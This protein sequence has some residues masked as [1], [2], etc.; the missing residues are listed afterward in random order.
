MTGLNATTATTISKETT[1]M[2]GSTPPAAGAAIHLAAI[3]R[4][5]CL[6]TAFAV[7]LALASAASAAPAHAAFGIASFDGEVAADDAHAPFTQAGG[8]PYSASTSFELNTAINE[9]GFNGPDGGGLK[10]ARVDL[11]PG[12]IGNPR[13][14]PRCPKT[15]LIPSF[16]ETFAGLDP[17]TVCP[18]E[19]IVGIA[20]LKFTAGGGFIE[21]NAT[22]IFNLEPP[23][24]VTAQFGFSYINQKAFLDAV[25]REDG[26][27]GVS[28]RSRFINQGAPLY[29]VS[30]T[31][32]GVPADSS[33]D[34]QR[35]I[36]FPLPLEFAP[37]PTCNDFGGAFPL[38]GPSSSDIEPKALL[39]NPT[40]CTPPGEGLETTLHVESWAAG[41]ATDTASFESHLPPGAD[42]LNPLPPEDWGAPQGPT[43]CEDV[44]FDP[45]V[46]VE[47]TETRPDAPTGLDLELTMPTDGL[48]NPDGIAQANLKR[49]RITLPEGMTINPAAA[50]G[51]VACDDAQLGIGT[52]RPVACPPAAKIGTVSVE[53]PLLDEPLAGAVYV[54]SQASG[55]PASG[56]MFRIAIAIDDADTGVRIK[57]P[58][59]VSADPR[60]GRLV[61]T[62]D[63]NPQVPFSK[64]TVSL[65]SGARAPLANPSTCGPKTITSELSP[66]SAA[67]PDAPSA[68]EVVVD[69]DTFVVECP[70]ANGFAPSFRAGSVNATGGAFSPFAA[71]IERRQGEQFLSGVRVDMPKGLLARL[72]GVELCSA[73]VAAE[74]TA[75]SC[76]AG[77]RVGTATIGAGSG[78]PFHL[79]GPVYLTGPYKGAPYGLSVQVHA[80]AGPFDLGIVKVAN[81][82]HVDPVTAQ[83][84]VVSDRLPQ[85]V[86]G[87]PVRLRSVN[88]DVDR[89]GF[90][91]NPTSCEETRVGATLTS[92]TGAVRTTGSRFQVGD[93][94]SLPF[95]PRL[96]LRLIGRKQT[97]TGKH[98]G[99][100][101][102]VRQT[103]LGEAGI[104]KAV[105]RL[106]RTLA[107]DADNARALCEFADGIRDDLEKRCPEGS[108]VGRARATTPLLDRPLTGNVYFVKNVR[109]DPRTGRQIRTLPMIVAAL[110]GE[111]AINLKGTSSVRGGRLVSTFAGVPDAPISRFDLDIAGGRRGI[112][113][114]TDS[115]DGPLSVCRGPQTAQV[116]TDGQN[117]KQRDFLVRVKT[118]CAKP[119][120][121]GRR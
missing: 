98:P 7:L 34:S 88:V 109:V 54:R 39:T 23:P 1:S 103:G 43:G 63:D 29:G 81:A 95:K 14:V 22:P 31:L 13:A 18:R 59:S 68:A 36:A 19:T 53:T 41:G 74:G 2:S 107:L 108:I 119:K 4:K 9:Q 73:A 58:G 50:A 65:K 40:T 104:G 93:C 92:V 67:D 60:S 121:S 11:P 49:A 100:R 78:S 55:D 33:H 6:V 24:G 116:M 117:G 75:G 86:K 32:W 83:V 71:R 30:V 35:C 8:H 69:T 20:A 62:F 70:A 114:V 57:L 21:T 112:L 12:L 96:A 56:E 46:S 82:L 25:L 101:A 27:Y 16:S 38:L 52:G 15:L 37:V 66:W 51:L 42:I 120:G 105:V 113:L 111:I 76:P 5:A 99:V 61:T 110:R 10:T 106:P 72:K 3:A 26:T 87:V 47:P 85:I 115:A 118:P 17:Q 77:S 94:A 80:K 91:I 79:Q 84:S 64:L 90:T 89:P 45:A 44:P 48:I 102:T 97:T 28:V